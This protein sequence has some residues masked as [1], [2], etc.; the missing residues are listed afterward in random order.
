MSAAV[1]TLTAE[2]VSLKN[3]V[4][5]LTALPAPANG[6]SPEMRNTGAAIQW[7][8]EGGSWADLVQLTALT[9]AAG[10]AGPIGLTGPT[11]PAGPTGASGTA[12]LSLRL[13]TASV[14]AILLGGSLDVPV[15]WSSP[16]PDDDYQIHL[17]AESGLLGRST[18]TVKSKTKTGCVVTV[19]STSLAITAGSI[20]VALALDF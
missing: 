12:N 20:L 7:R 19:T 5:Q 18:Q 9:G 6:K 1:Q 8:Q 16:M 11:G 3:Q 2:L 10:P 17:A 15:T 4:Q 13:A 14:P